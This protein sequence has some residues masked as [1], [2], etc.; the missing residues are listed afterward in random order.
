M[1][2]C[3]VLTLLMLI[4]SFTIGCSSSKNPSLYIVERETG[5]YVINLSEIFR[6]SQD[7]SVIYVYYMD[8]MRADIQ[9][10]NPSELVEDIE[11]KLPKHIYIINAFNGSSLETPVKIYLHST[12]IESMVRNYLRPPYVEAY[13]LEM[14]YNFVGDKY[15]SGNLVF[16]LFYRTEEDL[17][18]EYNKIL[19][20]IK[21]YSLN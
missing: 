9:C 21:S 10:E 15:N 11:K 20:W 18:N 1:K 17:D 6:I 7:E 8:G 12:N 4:M 13:Y 2:K 3:L 5:I 19:Q 16:N 14:K